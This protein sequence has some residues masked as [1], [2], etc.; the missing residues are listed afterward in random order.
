M[1]QAA[2][3]LNATRYSQAKQPSH[4]AATEVDNT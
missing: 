4:K 2:V 3:I 1:D